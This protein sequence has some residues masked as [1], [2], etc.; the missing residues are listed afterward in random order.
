MEYPQTNFLKGAFKPSRR[1][2]RGKNLRKRKNIIHFFKLAE[3]SGNF[4]K[5]LKFSRLNPNS[6][7]NS[8]LINWR[9]RFRKGREE[10]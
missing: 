7:N 4:G 5:K 10:H 3:T 2:L 8:R 6:H 1:S 9:L